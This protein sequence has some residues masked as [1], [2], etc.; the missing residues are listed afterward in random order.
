M[1]QMRKGESKRQMKV[2]AEKQL[3]ELELKLIYAL[4]FTPHKVELRREQIAEHKKTFAK[5]LT[6]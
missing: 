3:L 1:E 4:D 5:Y 2:I 6:Y